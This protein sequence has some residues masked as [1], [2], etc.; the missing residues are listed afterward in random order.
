[1][2]TPQNPAQQPMPQDLTQ[3]PKKKGGCMKWGG[4]GVAA[5]VLIGI[6][7]SLSGG[8]DDSDNTASSSSS[9][10]VSSTVAVEAIEE[11][12]AVVPEAVEESSAPASS[13]DD[14]PREYRNALRSAERYLDYSAFSYAGLYDQLTSE[15]G[16]SYPA[17]A[18]QYAVDNVEV[19]WNEEAVE[20][21]RNYQEYSAFSDS[22]LYDQ[23]ISEY[24][25]QFTPEQAQYAIDNY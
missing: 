10:V 5:L 17:E 22:G 16:D 21:A 4:I 13:S 8:G 25:H 2:T 3:K 20:A 18:A 19:D 7:S 24:G 11:E 6:G 23:L 9:S 12:A 1:M 15:Y 14:V